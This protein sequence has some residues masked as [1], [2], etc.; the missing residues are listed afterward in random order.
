MWPQTAWESN[1]CHIRSQCVVAFVCRQSAKCSNAATAA[2][3]MLASTAAAT[4]F[5]LSLNFDYHPFIIWSYR[6]CCCH[7]ATAMLKAIAAAVAAAVV[8]VV[9]CCSILY[10]FF[11]IAPACIVVLF[12]FVSPN[13]WAHRSARCNVVVH[14]VVVVHVAVA[15]SL[16]VAGFTTATRAKSAARLQYLCYEHVRVCLCVCGYFFSFPLLC[17]PHSLSLLLRSIMCRNRHPLL[18]PVAFCNMHLSTQKTHSFSLFL[19]CFLSLYLSVCLPLS[20]FSA[21]VAFVRVGKIQLQ[22]KCC[23]TSNLKGKTN[24]FAPNCLFVLNWRFMSQQNGTI[25]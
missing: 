12:C 4:S 13:T 9:N 14:V 19:S 8:A 3:A 6:C 2:A 25:N 23:L 16:C 1:H 21:T 7:S 24:R 5:E 15:V 22:V 20:V 11:C 10:I 17:L 18:W